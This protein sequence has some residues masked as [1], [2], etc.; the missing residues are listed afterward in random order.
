MKDFTFTFKI[1][2]FESLNRLLKFQISKY[3]DLYLFPPFPASSRLAHSGFHISL[4]ASGE[5]HL[6]MH[7]PVACLHLGPK[8]KLP[9]NRTQFL[10]DI[11]ASKNSILTRIDLSNE[12]GGGLIA[13]LNAELMIKN[14]LKSKYIR[15]RLENPKFIDYYNLVLTNPYSPSSDFKE[16]FPYRELEI[17]A[18]TIE[19]AIKIYKGEK[20]YKLLIE[21]KNNNII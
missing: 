3:N 7:F 16:F 6:R 21:L 10:E 18:K 11:V 17:D 14:F 13:V 15:D 8:L 5:S 19:D 9:F 12:T 1:K 20:L 2:N 4:H